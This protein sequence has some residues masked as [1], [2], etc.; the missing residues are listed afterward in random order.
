M[1]NP[2]N[3]KTCGHSQQPEGGH[4]YMFKT[5]PVEVCMKHTAH[6]RIDAGTIGHV[7]NYGSAGMQALILANLLSRRLR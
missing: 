3:C 2:N 4:C 5:A 1:R 6:S 7:S